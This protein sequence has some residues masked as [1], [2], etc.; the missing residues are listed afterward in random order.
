VQVREEMRVDAAEGNLFLP[1]ADGIASSHV[2]EQPLSAGLDQRAVAEPLRRGNRASRADK[3]D[4]HELVA[5]SRRGRD[6]KNEATR[7]HG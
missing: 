6:G 7:D 5:C 3:G 1:Q 4:G 2:E